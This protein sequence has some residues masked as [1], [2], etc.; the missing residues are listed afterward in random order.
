[1]DR[2]KKDIFELTRITC[3]DYRELKKLPVILIADNIRSLQNVGSLMRT[4]D[5]FLVDTLILGGITGT[6]PHPE[7]SKTAL[8]AEESVAWRHVDDLQTEAERLRGE[9]WKLYCLEQAHGSIPL[10][11]FEPQ[12]GER[13]A[14]IA[15]NEVDGVGQRLID[16]SDGCLEIPQSGTKHSL[17][18][19]VSG[20]IALWHFYSHLALK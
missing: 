2:K 7:I 18:V 13:Y 19:A 8:G 10:Q 9:G 16:L 6:P 3:S 11:A 14:L 4:C 12:P 15:G 5:A 20:G 1:M 17:N